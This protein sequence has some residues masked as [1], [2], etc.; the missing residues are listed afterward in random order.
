ML[1]ILTLNAAYI[2]LDPAQPATRLEMIIAEAR[3]EL[4]I[5]KSSQPRLNG[6]PSART[7]LIDDATGLVDIA[8]EPQVESEVSSA[9]LFWSPQ[10]DPSGLA[11]VLFTSGST[12]RPKGVE[13]PRS[14]VSNLL[15]SMIKEP[16]LAESDVMLAVS[17][18]MFDIAVLELF[19]PLCV[20]GTV[21][22]ADPEEVKDGRRLRAVLDAK[23]VSVM[24]AT[25]TMWHMLIDSG[26]AGSNGLRILVGGEALSPDLARQLLSRGEVWNMYGPT[27]TTVW[28]TCKRV[29]R[30][31]SITIGRPIANTRL[32]VV[33]GQG[34]VLPR[35]VVGELCIG[36]AGLARGYLRRPELTA[37]RFIQMPGG[38]PGERIYRTGDLARLLENGEYE[39][40]GRIDQQVKIRGF[41]VELG[42]VEHALLALD[43]VNRAAVV[44]WER[45]GH[46][47]MLVAYVVPKPGVP[48]NPQRLARQLRG[49]L[50]AY[51]LPGRYIEMRSLP[52]TP[53]NKIDRNALPDPRD[54]R[55]LRPLSQPSV[56]RTDTEQ[57]LFDI[58]TDV[59]AL[60]YI[61]IDDDFFDLGGQSV[62]AVRI[63]NRIHRALHVDLAVS[64]L[65]ENRTIADLAA[66][67][68]T[69]TNGS[70]TQGWSSVVPIQPHGQLSPIFCV[71]GIGGNPLTFREL[72][73]AL[74]PQQPV[75][76]LQHRGVDGLRP[77]HTSVEEMA[78]EFINDIRTVCATG[79]YVLAGHSAGGLVAYEMAQ[80]LTLAGEEVA[81]VIL[82]DTVRP[83]LAGYSKRERAR[84]HWIKLR[85][86]GA[87]YL[88]HRVV[89]R[90]SN[91][92]ERVGTRL[93]AALAV[94]RPYRFRL[95]AVTMAGLKAESAYRPDTYYGD[96][97]LFQSNP[98]I[99][100][101]RGVRNKQHVANGWLELVRGRLD[102]FAVDAGHLDILEGP[103]APQISTKIRRALSSTTPTH[104][105]GR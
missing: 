84:E 6:S 101:E 64:A 93:G 70:T 42:E 14:A 81:L 89:D 26:W 3:P 68:D 39:C 56:P 11:Y 10:E 92:V 69:L 105:G 71:S 21:H 60:Q 27:E 18:T 53:N 17:T 82:F 13:I 36:G 31:D 23:S 35:G 95:S 90:T 72:A 37:E 8:T 96:V 45:S 104:H 97:L 78:Q 77:P 80:S 29:A 24:Q 94:Y 28:S 52:L 67:I 91:I 74:G 102:V 44:K 5:T 58:W 55:N 62:L 59:L 51:M 30:S 73:D 16:G 1:A 40:L 79:P 76:G 4:M 88:L 86:I 20:G 57:K 9:G 100:S 22:I 103:A 48:L 34:R 25:P 98:H 75:Y 49:T 54:T 15:A 66:Y 12:G 33:D 61:S 65:L 46:M 87:G 83:H 38:V 7:V 85:A 50:P 63:C 47:P 99:G 32:S 41:R 19:G 2:P 43:E